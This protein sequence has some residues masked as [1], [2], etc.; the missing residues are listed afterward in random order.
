MYK[1]IL[2]SSYYPHWKKYKVGQICFWKV[3]FQV[4]SKAQLC[5]QDHLL[6]HQISTRKYIW[7]CVWETKV[8]FKIGRRICGEK[9]LIVLCSDL[10]DH[11]S[12]ERSQRAWPKG[13]VKQ[14]VMNCSASQAEAWVPRAIPRRKTAGPGIGKRGV[15]WQSG[16]RQPRRVAGGWKQK[17]KQSPRSSPWW[18]WWRHF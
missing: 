1:S 7:L 11:L 15:G 14:R 10:S 18:V 17:R 2:F 8:N 9:S 3:D 4:K 13:R 16:G 6:A 12:E 5:P